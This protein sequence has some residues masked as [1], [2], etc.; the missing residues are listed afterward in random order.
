MA[1]LVQNQEQVLSKEFLQKTLWP[2]TVVE[3]NSLYQVLTKLRK[4]LNDSSRKPKFI[5][6]VPKK[7]YCFI[8]TVST[9]AP[10]NE[11]HKLSFIPNTFT[12]AVMVLLTVLVLSY[13]LIKSID[14]QKTQSNYQLE[15]VSYQLGLEFDVS[16]HKNT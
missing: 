14:N 5:K 15:D 6:T 13:L 12:M 7:G 9:S 3:Q 10:A 1:L 2:N 11:G 4:L 8:A 16:V